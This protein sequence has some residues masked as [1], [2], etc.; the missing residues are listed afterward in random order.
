MKKL[1]GIWLLLVT[2]FN[3]SQEFEFIPICSENF[4][5][6]IKSNWKSIGPIQD[7]PNL[8]Q[9]LGFISTVEIHPKN[10][11][12]A[13][14][15]SNSGGIYKTNNFLDSLPVWKNVTDKLRLP[16]LGIN[17]LVLDQKNPKVL[18]ASTGCKNE[19]KMGLGV[20][21]SIDGGESWFPIGPTKLKKN[22][23]SSRI[24]IHNIHNQILF[25][26]INDQLYK[27][28]NAGKS[29]ELILNCQTLLD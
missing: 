16:G 23:I 5:S 9:N 28:I 15:S 18:Y 22:N 24:L 1:I 2:F 29:W 17:D 7:V 6:P 8:Q 25:C 11:N 20:L 12:I 19:N 27:S 26:A 4:V 13:Y 21:K 10:R 3:Y 14:S